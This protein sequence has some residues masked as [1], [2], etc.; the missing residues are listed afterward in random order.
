MKGS[1]NMHRRGMGAW[2][3]DT[4]ECP[5]YCHRIYSMTLFIIDESSSLRMQMQRADMVQM[6]MQRAMQM[7]MQRADIVALLPNID[8]EHGP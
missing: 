6:Q 4:R 3:T 1:S 5:P 8:Q 7:Q 2:Q